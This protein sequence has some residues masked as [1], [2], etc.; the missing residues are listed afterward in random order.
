MSASHSWELYA[1]DLFDRESPAQIDAR[2]AGLVDG[3]V[4]LWRR[5]LSEGVRDG[6]DRTFTSFSLHWDG[7]STDAGAQPFDNQALARMRRWV[8]GTPGPFEDNGP[9]NRKAVLARE[10]A[11]LLRAIAEAHARLHVLAGAPRTQ[12]YVADSPAGQLRAVALA[13]TS[14]VELEIKLTALGAAPT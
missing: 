2:G 4:E 6:G 1:A 9:Q 3:L 5:V 14:A 11:V 12:G 13:T 8:F 10:N 7:G